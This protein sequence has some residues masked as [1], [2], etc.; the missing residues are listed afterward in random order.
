MIALVGCSFAYIVTAELS[1]VQYGAT[2]AQLISNAKQVSFSQIFKNDSTGSN[3]ASG[4]TRTTTNYTYSIKGTA[5]ATDWLWATMSG[6]DSTH[7]YYFDWKKSGLSIRINNYDT[8]LNA[9]VVFTGLS[10]LQYAINFTNG[11]Y[12]DVTIKPILIDLTATFGSGLEPSLSECEAIFNQEYYAYGSNT[13]DVLV[14]GASVYASYQKPIIAKLVEFNQLV[15]NIDI[16][17]T[18]PQWEAFVQETINAGDKLYVKGSFDVAVNIGFYA[19]GTWKQTITGSSFNKI[20]TMTDTINQVMLASPSS[21]ATSTNLQIYNITTIFGS[22]QEPDL[23]TCQALFNAPYYAYTSS[24]QMQLLYDG[25]KPIALADLPSGY[26]KL[27][28]QTG[29][30]TYNQIYGKLA[31]GNFAMFDVTGAV[32]N[33]GVVKREANGNVAVP[34]TPTNNNHATSKAYVDGLQPTSQTATETITTSTTLAYT[35]VS[36]TLQAGTYLVYGL[37]VWG[38]NRPTAIAINQSSSSSDNGQFAY[39]SMGSGGSHLNACG[40]RIFNNA[41]TIYLWAQYEA[42]SSNVVQLT[43]VKLA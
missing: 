21:G 36:L 7:K 29:A 13:I 30:T 39:N 23:A 31:N 18:M 5:S 20:V 42:S 16:N 12:Y 22:G 1:Y 11:T 28:K 40:V 8:D 15:S 14:D 24:A 25:T 38:N 27:D 35:G 41:T 10:T 4:I 17:R 6:L 43:A 37:A 2:N 32:L 9:P 34:L 26:N 3:T 33:D 19:S